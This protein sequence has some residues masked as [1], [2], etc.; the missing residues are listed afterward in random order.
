M[1]TT[2]LHLVV[3]D[4]RDDLGETARDQLAALA[5]GLAAADG[6]EATLAACS[7]RE[8]I[9]ATW[10]RSLDDLEAFASSAHHLRFVLEGV[11]QHTTGMWSAAASV[12]AGPPPE[13]A[14]GAALWA[15]GLPADPPAFEWQVRDLLTAIEELPGHCAAG[16]TTE[17]RER[18]RAAGV[19][20]VPSGEQAAFGSALAGARASWGELGANLR[21]ALAPLLAS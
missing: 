12:P 20:V 18:V 4:L 19:V 3:A 1:T 6:V 16:P 13:G 17:E 2:L 14:D 21:D 8:L 9:T 5:R 15:F 10:L 7:Q 11:A